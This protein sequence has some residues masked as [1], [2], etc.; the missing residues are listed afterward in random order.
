MHAVDA[1]PA[2]RM[3]ACSVNVLDVPSGSQRVRPPLIRIDDRDDVQIATFT[4]NLGMR[5]GDG[6]GA[7]EANARSSSVRDGY[8]LV[9]LAHVRAPKSC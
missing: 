7:D 2:D 9:I 6:S 3:V 1:A 4:K 5:R 8:A